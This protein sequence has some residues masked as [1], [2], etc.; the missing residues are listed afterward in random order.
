MNNEASN[1]MDKKAIKLLMIISILIGV[2]LVVVNIFLFVVNKRSTLSDVQPY[3]IPLPEG[4]SMKPIDV[5]NQRER[6]LKV[7][8]E[9]FNREGEEQ[10]TT[11]TPDNNGQNVTPTPTSE[12]VNGNLGD[13][14]LNQ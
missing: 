2:T 13:D 14:L 6:Y 11:P 4:F 8:I 1:T 12:A 7:S 3:L 10:V 5:I 9:D